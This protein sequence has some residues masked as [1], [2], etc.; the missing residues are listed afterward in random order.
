MGGAGQQCGV[1]GCRDGREWMCE[2]GAASPGWW[3]RR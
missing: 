2:R 1:G 3:W